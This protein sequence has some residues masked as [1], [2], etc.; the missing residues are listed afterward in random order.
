MN[1]VEINALIDTIE[2]HGLS[3]VLLIL[4]LVTFVIPWIVKMQK[5]YDSGRGGGHEESEYIDEIIDLER[6]VI[7]SLGQTAVDMD[8]QWATLWQFHNGVSSVDGVPFVR[9]SI[10]HEFTTGDVKPRLD[11]Y[12]AIPISVFIDA[13]TAIRMSGYLEVDLA[14]QFKSLVNSYKRDGIH[15]AILVP[16]KNSTGKIVGV[17]SVAYAGSRKF[18]NPEERKR[19]MQ[20]HATCIAMQLSQLASFRK[21]LTRRKDDSSI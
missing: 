15:H 17:L 20:D 5:Y 10:T 4:L 13:I 9:M 7:E 18:T 2:T 12:Q 16:V 8:S 6:D 3:L 19:V 14:S 1:L 11:L 21:R